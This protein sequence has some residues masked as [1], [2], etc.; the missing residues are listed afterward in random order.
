[1]RT[2]AEIEAELC[3]LELLSPAGAIGN[4]FPNK[5]YPSARW[6]AEVLRWV[7]E[8]GAPSPADRI[9]RL[10]REKAQATK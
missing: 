7:L 3:R 2:R 6:S 9:V 8:T 1:M 10:W 5:C 4:N